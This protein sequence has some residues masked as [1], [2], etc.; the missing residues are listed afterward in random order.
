MSPLD[1]GAGLVPLS[2]PSPPASQWS[3]FGFPIRA[4]ALCI[5]AG[6]VVGVWLAMRRW[7]ARGGN[8]ETLETVVLVAVPLGI[9]GARVYHVITDYQ[10]YFGPGRHPIDALKIWNG[11][12]GIWGAVIFGVIGAGLV[13]RKRGAKFA[14]IADSCAPG[15]LIAQGIGRIGNYFNQE[16]FGE[17]TTL[18]WALQIDLAHRP[19]GYTQY[20]TFHPTFLYELLWTFAMAAI[21]LWAD[22]R[23]TLGRG[24]VFTLYVVL[25]T[26]G[27]FWIEALRIDTVNEIGGFRLN[28]YTSGIVFVAALGFLVYLFIRR[29]GRETDV[30]A[31]AV[32]PL[33]GAEAVEPTES[34]TVGLV[35]SVDA[36][37]ADGESQADDP[38]IAGETDETPTPDPESVSEP[39]SGPASE[40]AAEPTAERPV[41]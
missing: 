16:L 41:R 24:K 17:P 5:M 19:V 18:P 12:L 39:T 15:I 7:K 28:N 23:F 38:D 2:F 20:E 22:R 14:A 40:S 26:L 35:G 11:G 1:L 31:T 13:A 4:Y 3:L 37:A 32:T 6:I 34:G 29:P 27:R 10:L 36:A 25:Y 21:L 9:V 33:D 8:T 30:D